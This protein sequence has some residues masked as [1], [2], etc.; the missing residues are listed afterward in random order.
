MKNNYEELEMEVL[1]FNTNKIYMANDTGLES[2]IPDTDGG[3]G[4]PGE[5]VDPDEWD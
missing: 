3:N 2:E 5:T 1:D 4:N